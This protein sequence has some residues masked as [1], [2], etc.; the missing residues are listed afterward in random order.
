MVDVLQDIINGVF[1]SPVLLKDERTL[2]ELVGHFFAGALRYA[3]FAKDTADNRREHV[4]AMA[5]GFALLGF[6]QQCCAIHGSSGGLYE[7]VGY[8]VT[9]WGPAG[10]RRRMQRTCGESSNSSGA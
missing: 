5:L 3:R 6:A 8:R 10:L 4:T 1:A 9:N 2:T 7:T